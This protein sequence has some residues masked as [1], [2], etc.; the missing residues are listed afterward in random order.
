MRYLGLDLGTKT[1]GV[2]I[3]DKSNI[4][5]SPFK[6]IRFNFEDYNAPIGE[7]REII[8]KNNIT[9]IVLGNPINMDGSK[10]F[11]SERSMKFKVILE[12]EFNL[13]VTLIDERLSSIE[14]HNILSNN[15]KK[16]IEHKKN[17]DAVAASLILESFL[18]SKGN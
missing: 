8:E 6:T 7:L 14:A 13:P 10:G 1:L 5:A 4:L 15:G 2:A 16:E 11:A 12:N 17:V 9:E 18:K 3:T